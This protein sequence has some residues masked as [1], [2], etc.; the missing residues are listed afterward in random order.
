MRDFLKI[1]THVSGAF[2]CDPKLPTKFEEAQRPEAPGVQL[3]WL[4]ALL[5]G[6][7]TIP[8]SPG[9]PARAV[10]MLL[11]GPPGTGK[12][13]LATELCY[14]WAAAGNNPFRHFYY[15]TTEA[16]PLWLVN[17]AQQLWGASARQYFEKNIEVVEYTPL[18][19]S[20]EIPVDKILGATAGTTERAVTGLL[21]L[22]ANK[23]TK[24]IFNSEEL[25][26]NQAD[27]VVIDS[28]N[29]IPEDSEKIEWLQETSKLI[30]S[31]PK[32]IILVMDAS[33]TSRSMEFWEYISDII[34]R[35]DHTHPTSP[36]EGYLLR[37]IEVV[38]ARYQ[39]H[40]WGP[41]QLKLYEPYDIAKSTTQEKEH[42]ETY[43]ERLRR[44]HPFRE[45]GGV[46]IYPSIHYLLSTYK[47][48]D[49]SFEP[50][51]I[52]P[53][54]QV[55]ASMLEGGF[56]EGR[57]TAFL[58]AR[59]GHKSYL[60]FMHVVDR[61]VFHGEC[62]LIIS[63][64]DDVG[65]TVASINKILDDWSRDK[66]DLRKNKRLH[67]RLKG[68]WDDDLRE[69]LE[70]MYFPPGN[71]TPEEFLHRM[72]LS[73]WRLK[74]VSPNVTVL[75][76]SLDQLAARFPFCARE[77][78]FIAALLQ[79]LCA[80]RV[81]SL[82][83]AASKRAEDATYH[84]PDSIHGVDSIAELIID[85][86]QQEVTLTDVQRRHALESFFR[87]QGAEQPADD[88]LTKLVDD[89]NAWLGKPQVVARVVRH[90]GG[91]QAGARAIMEL[92]EKGHPLEKII[93][94]GLQCFPL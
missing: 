9:R 67:L 47:R 16:D 59:G 31:G 29:A 73:V 65:I 26:T 2:W 13:T 5:D 17:N 55:L 86:Q 19:K 4:D 3:C 44:A 10:T 68:K 62:G 37:T 21:R 12:S 82:F 53:R 54:S 56:P 28:L 85:F 51:L 71:I 89:W 80:N 83:V 78:V 43:F 79:V 23:D 15:A 34:I 52:P 74:K 25:L 70:I 81:T 58:G 11:T 87:V 64:R 27:V 92:I 8:S 49:P 50:T 66:K 90:A 36:A 7:I 69:R 61:V 30:K 45:Q 33:S 20:H 72:L 32:L 42:E 35:L 39:H 6:G 40:A 94:P 24:S 41:H 14:R 91:H 88:E 38:K 22:F 75:F 93:P 60:G 48:S 63:L 84:G 57:C 46:F 76:N 18:I 1:P 77:P